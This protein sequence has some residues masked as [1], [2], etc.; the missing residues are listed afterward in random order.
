AL[1]YSSAM[2]ATGYE[3]WSSAMRNLILFLLLYV[4]LSGARPQEV[5]VGGVLDLGSYQ[6]KQSDIAIKLAIQDVHNDPTLLNGTRLQFQ[7]TEMGSTA[8]INA[9]NVVKLFRENVISVVAPMTTDISNFVS[10][11]ADSAQVPLFTFAGNDPSMYMK[12]SAYS[13]QMIGRDAVQMK[14]IASLLTRYYWREVVVIFQD[15]ELGLSGILALNNALQPF[16]ARIVQKFPVS[17]D[18]FNN[19]S[20]T[21]ILKR[22]EDDKTRSRVFLLHTSYGLARTIFLEAEHSGILK[23]QGFVWI[24]TEWVASSLDVPDDAIMDSMQGVIGVRR[25]IPHTPLFQNISTRWKDKLMSLYPNVTHSE[26]IGIVGAY[27]YDSIWIIAKAIDALFRDSNLTEL[28]FKSS[29]KY[30]TDVNIFQEGNAL[31]QKAAENSFEGITGKITF[32]KTGLL[33]VDSYDIVNVVKREIRVVGSWSKERLSLARKG[34]EIIWPNG[35]S[36]P[37]SGSRKLLVGVP[38]HAV[39]AKFVNITDD[40]KNFSGFCIDVFQRALE[41]LP[42]HLDYDFQ[43]S[44]NGNE[45]PDYN[46]LVEQ[47][48]NKTFDA[49]VADITILADRVAKVDFTQP[50]TD[51]GLVIMVRVKKNKSSGW[52][53]LEPFTLSMWLTT[54]AFV[55]L[56]AAIFWLLERG[57]NDALTGK[58]VKQME[59]SLWFSFTTIVFAHREKVMTSLGKLI[60]IIWLFVVLILNSSYTASLASILTVQQLS[61]TIRD[62]ETLR[63]SNVAVGHLTGSFVEAYLTDELKIDKSRLVSLVK[64]EDYV[65]PLRNGSIGAI[66]DETPY[67]HMVMS[68]HCGEFA[69]VGR[70]FYRGGFGFLF[71]KGSPVVGEMTSAVLNLTQ[72]RTELEEIRS[73]WF[74]PQSSSS[75]VD[76]DG[77]GG[78]GQLSLRTF[79]GLFVITT[80][81]YC[82]F[83]TAYAGL[84][85]YK[86][87]QINT[88]VQDVQS[89]PIPPATPLVAIELG[90]LNSNLS[91][92]SPPSPQYFSSQL[93]PNP[94]SDTNMVH[95]RRRRARS[96]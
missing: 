70:A 82:L 42:Y 96:A 8:L 52:P 15:D 64:P 2:I 30:S 39:F 46:D 33:E 87:R 20:W 73:K 61:P 35:Y 37:P 22:L 3:L 71:A 91:S 50:Y 84:K 12:H 85:F 26:N 57:E 10:F 59:T 45:N 43:V 75:C 27:A 17:H 89:N 74:G 76:A 18:S 66:V 49:V 67:I 48:A 83:I 63:S 23:K 7:T 80:T 24:V 9:G 28:G 69:T 86:S 4:G 79:W 36:I 81:I 68:K 21:E 65:I 13:I 58:T 54:A 11:V 34:L 72:N 53:F 6:G 56:T 19:S 94:H 16:S 60:L 77:G 90:P 25:N 92:S 14:A 31:F 41:K 44:V 47:V 95:P 5:T 78:S 93:Y 32:S 88:R 51:T 29:G 1:H 55:V 62:I 40:N 38:P